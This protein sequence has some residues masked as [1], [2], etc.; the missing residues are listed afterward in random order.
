[1][2]KDYERKD[3]M[4]ILTDKIEDI[5][6]ELIEPE[7]MDSWLNWRRL[8]TEY[9]QAEANR[10]MALIA[11]DKCQNAINEARLRVAAQEASEAYVRREL[12]ATITVREQD[13]ARAAGAVRNFAQQIKDA[14][15]KREDAGT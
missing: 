7:A 3:Q 15:D 13:R 10:A 12:A 2:S 14:A 5:A 6:A 4:D 1:M 9:S 8:Q 11:Y